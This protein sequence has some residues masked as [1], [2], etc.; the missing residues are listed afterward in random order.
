[1]KNIIIFATFGL[2]LLGCAPKQSRKGEP[3]NQDGFPS[4]VFETDIHD[5][6]T[7]REGEEVGA[8]FWFKNQGDAPLIISTVVA[9]CGC[10][11]AYWPKQPVMPND[12][13]KIVVLFNSQ[14]REGKQVKSIKVMSN[15]PQNEHE[16]MIATFVKSTN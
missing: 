14:G 13:D 10:T 1:M 5:F 6:G 7:I 15:A 11:T 4:I 2:F 12:S 8:E 16:L 3:V 9:G